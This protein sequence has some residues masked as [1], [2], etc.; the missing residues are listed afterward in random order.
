MKLMIMGPGGVL[1]NAIA[2]TGYENLCFMIKD[3]EPLAKAIFDKV[4]SILVRYYEICAPFD[5]VGALMSNDD[6]G[7]KGQTMLSTEDMRKY[8]FGWHKKIVEKIHERNKPAILHS[9]GDLGKVMDDVIDDMKFDAKHS[10]EDNIMPVEKIYDLYSER[11]AILG[12]IDM[13]F[14]CREEPEMI[15]N[16]SYEMLEK[17]TVNGGY[18]LGSGNSIPCYVPHKNFYSMILASRV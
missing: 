1:E 12:G 17:S 5:T 16:R 2:L 15:F 10:Y 8:V 13:D 18:A 7:F 14:L 9:C 4:G 11:I 3:N 6:W